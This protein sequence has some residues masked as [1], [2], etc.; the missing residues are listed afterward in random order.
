[1]EIQIK[2][3]QSSSLDEGEN[4]MKSRTVIP[5]QVLLLGL[6]GKDFIFFW[7]HTVL[8]CTVYE[9]Q[10]GKKKVASFPLSLS[11][12]DVHHDEQKTSVIKTTDRFSTLL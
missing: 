4:E 10:T 12:G 9:N 1:M 2:S 5:L 3:V 8:H 7:D 6:Q 11:T